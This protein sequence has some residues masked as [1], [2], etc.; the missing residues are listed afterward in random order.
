MCDEYC[1]KHINTHELCICRWIACNLAKGGKALSQSANEYIDCL[2]SLVAS[3]LLVPDSQAWLPPEGHKF[4]LR[5]SA[6]VG[7]LAGKIALS[8]EYLT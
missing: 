7:S 4:A 5:R 2:G 6:D 8:L 3:G 1:L